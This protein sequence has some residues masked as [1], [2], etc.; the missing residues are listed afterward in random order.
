MDRDVGDL[1]EKVAEMWCD[2][3]GMTANRSYEDERGW[4]CLAEFTLTEDESKTAVRPHDRDLRGVKAFVQVKSTNSRRGR[5]SIKLSNWKYLA[6]ETLH[7]C[8]ILVL[9]FDGEDEPQRAYL[10]HVGEDLIERILQRLREVSE[11]DTQLHET[12]TSVSYG[13]EERLENESGHALRA[14][15]VETIEGNPIRYKAWKRRCLTEVGYEGATV[16][17]Q[18]QAELPSD[19]EGDPEGFI[20]DLSAGLQSS[21]DLEV[22][23][24]QDL[25]FGDPATLSSFPDHIRLSPD[26]ETEEVKLIFSAGRYTRERINAN[27]YRPSELMEKV[28]AGKRK[29]RFSMPYADLVVAED[30]QPLRFDVNLPPKDTPVALADLQPLAKLILF[31]QEMY[32]ENQDFTIKVSDLSG[33]PSEGTIGAFSGGNFRAEETLGIA[34]RR[35]RN[36]WRVWK[37]LDE[38]DQVKVT[39]PHILENWKEYLLLKKALRGE[40]VPVSLEYGLFKPYKEICGTPN[41]T[42]AI[43]EPFILITSTHGLIVGV[44]LMGEPESLGRKEGLDHYE[45][46]AEKTDVVYKDTFLEGEE[47]PFDDAMEIRELCAERIDEEGFFVHITAPADQR[48][49]GSRES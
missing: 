45:L 31:F 41:P 47:T 36:T 19:Y 8:F 34:A 35:I 6:T 22:D 16:R 5:V 28:P 14:A 43:P 33:N 44:V 11:E 32:E 10:I 21:L 37:A 12:S 7:P 29:L 24:A 46:S 23:E 9:E 38:Q 2:Q 40:E 3:A 26:H 30:A 48:E 15:I 1:G 42:V 18:G 49:P 13:E 4:D 39:M 17:V 20:A 25:R 27:L